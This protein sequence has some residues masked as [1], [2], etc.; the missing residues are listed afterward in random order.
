M[1][2]NGL[3]PAPELVRAPFGLET[4][5][6]VIRHNR[7]DEHW[8]Q[9]YQQET[10]HCHY[11]A[12]SWSPCTQAE[13][14]EIYDQDGDAWETVQPFFVQAEDT[15]TDA[16]ALRRPEARE[17]LLEL[18]DHLTWKAAERELWFGDHV[19]GLDP[20]DFPDKPDNGWLLGP[21]SVSVGT[22]LS[23]R[24]GLARV[25]ERMAV[26]FPNTQGVVHMSPG[27]AV[28]L[29]DSLEANPANDPT[30]MRV[31]A[32]GTPVVIG[33][34]YAV[35]TDGIQDR[36]FGTGPVTVHV[37]P[38]EVITPDLRTGAVVAQ[39]EFK[40]MAE[41]PVS[42]HFDGCSHVSATITYA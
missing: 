14:H 10:G 13:T 11:R 15:C 8:A 23:P 19:Q 39:N 21:G 41:R 27:A 36:I 29:G 22:G 38:A 6:A 40:L 32:T 30:I 42:V 5:A 3:A 17:R 28:M 1:P 34:G 12:G 2:F 25:L 20:A 31:K 4:V 9:G 35:D 24:V 18:I 33:Q 7:D 16:R 37:G 26:L